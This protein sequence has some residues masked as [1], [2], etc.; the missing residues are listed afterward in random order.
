VVD[1][2]MKHFLAV[3]LEPTASPFGPRGASS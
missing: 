1:R 2:I 3:A